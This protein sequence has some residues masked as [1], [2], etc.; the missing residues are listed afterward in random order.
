MENLIEFIGWV[1]AQILACNTAIAAD[2][3]FSKTVSD[4]TDLFVE[5][6]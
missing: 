3:L 1:L 5:A 4:D 6:V 2:A